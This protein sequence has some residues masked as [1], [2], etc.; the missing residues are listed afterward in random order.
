MTTGPEL[1][2][3]LRTLHFEKYHNDTDRNSAWRFSNPSFW[4]LIWLKTVSAYE[5][6]FPSSKFCLLTKKYPY[7]VS[8]P[9]Q[10]EL[11]SVY[12]CDE[13]N[14]LV[15]LLVK[16]FLNNG[17]I[18]VYQE[19]IHH[20]RLILNFPV[21]TPSNGKNIISLKRIKAI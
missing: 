19:R 14:L 13:K 6:S 1:F 8:E 5:S 20:I 9:F 21:S 10:N 3:T 18:K 16:Y 7:F 11:T 4:W 2:L 12:F 15:G 17:L